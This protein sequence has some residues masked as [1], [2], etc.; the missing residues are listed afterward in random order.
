MLLNTSAILEIPKTYSNKNNEIIILLSKDTF[1]WG[2]FYVRFFSEVSKRKGNMS[3]GNNMIKCIASKSKEHTQEIWKYL[4]L[5]KNS[6]WVFYILYLYITVKEGRSKEWCDLLI[7]IVEYIV[8][9]FMMVNRKLF[10]QQL[11][12]I[13]I[14]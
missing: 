12:H 5:R 11:I 14:D 8:L 2:D 6:V 13:S 3:W 9:Y 10:V 1:I 7:K 4:D